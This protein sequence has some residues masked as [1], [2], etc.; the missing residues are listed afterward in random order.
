MIH[1]FIEGM[2]LTLTDWLENSGSWRSACTTMAFWLYC[3]FE[4]LELIT[5]PQHLLVEKRGRHPEVE[6]C[7]F[8]WGAD[9][10]RVGSCTLPFGEEKLWPQV[11]ILLSYV[12]L[13]WWFFKLFE[14]TFFGIFSLK[15]W[16]KFLQNMMLKLP[17]AS[18]AWFLQRRFVE[19]GRPWQLP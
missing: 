11:G 18:K 17:S 10:C 7:S 3:Y 1:W 12:V 19:D 16:G 6:W 15:N 5:K 13:R 8:F 9:S 4:M 2:D 14:N